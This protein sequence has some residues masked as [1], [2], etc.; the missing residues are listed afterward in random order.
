MIPLWIHRDQGRHL[1]QVLAQE[2]Q[3]VAYDGDAYLR[4]IQIKKVI[5]L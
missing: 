3:S 1:R 4:N 2:D 5:F